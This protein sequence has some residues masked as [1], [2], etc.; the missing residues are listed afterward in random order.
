MYFS[1]LILTYADPESFVR[2]VPDFIT[3]L[4]FYFYFYLFFVEEGIKDS[5]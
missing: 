4:F 2:E 1:N 3:F 5:L